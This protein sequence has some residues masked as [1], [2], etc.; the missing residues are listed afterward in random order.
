MMEKNII[1]IHVQLNHFAAL[2]PLTQHCKSTMT[3]F[4]FLK[5]NIFI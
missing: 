4:F 3:Q 2:Q 5:M 1:K